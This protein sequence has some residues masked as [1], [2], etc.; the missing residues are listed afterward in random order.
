MSTRMNQIEK[1]IFDELK[2]LN[3]LEP[4]RCWTD[5]EWT[6]EVK[7]AVGRVGEE[8]GL[9]IHASGSKYCANG[10]WLYDMVWIEEGPK[11][12]LVDVPLVMETEWR[13][14]GVGA[15][16]RDEVSVDFRKLLLS[17][18]RH[19][20]M[21]FAARTAGRAEDRIRHLIDQ[22][23]ACGLSRPRDRYLFACWLNETRDFLY[24]LHVA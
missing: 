8:L 11:G 5:R 17:R 6:R 13:S 12:Q 7:H 4:K 20:L 15:D 2:T 24:K 21:V 10:E 16:F 19:R 9:K 18:A 3:S 22:V 23:H 14:H 1:R